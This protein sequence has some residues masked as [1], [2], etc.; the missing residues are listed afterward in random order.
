M[1]LP[2]LQHLHKPAERSFITLFAC[3]YYSLELIYVIAPLFVHYHL[4]SEGAKHASV[5]Q[6]TTFARHTDLLISF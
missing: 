5:Q 2:Q 3:Y 6:H 4:I 1:A